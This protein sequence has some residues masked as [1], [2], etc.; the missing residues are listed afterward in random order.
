MSEPKPG[1]GTEEAKDMELDQQPKPVRKADDSFSE[2][3]Q[4]E[5]TKR[6]GQ[7]KVK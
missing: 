1:T 7:R 3:D 4:T 6:K 2:L 5:Q